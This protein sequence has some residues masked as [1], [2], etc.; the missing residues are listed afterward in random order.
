[1]LDHPL[2]A[3]LAERLRLSARSH[4]RSKR[5]LGHPDQPHAV[6]DAAGPE[7][8]LGDRNPSPSL[9]SRLLA[10]TRTSV[11]LHLG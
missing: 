2:A 6:V 7:P 9:P 1:V 11:E 4:I 8:G 5:A 10:G 3:R